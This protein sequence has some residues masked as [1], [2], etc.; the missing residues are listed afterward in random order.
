MTSDV[1][2]TARAWNLWLL[3]GW[4]DV[5]TQYRRSFLGPV[6]ITVSTGV[7]VLA[8]GVL[9]AQLFGMKTEEF[10]PYFAVGYVLFVFLSTV[11]TDGCDT[12]SA[13]E[14][15][16]KHG[17]FPKLVFPLRV[18]VRNVVLLMHNAVIIIAVLISFGKFPSV[19]WIAFSI[20]LLLTLSVA[21]FVIVILGCLSARFRDVPMMVRS[22]MQIMFFMTPVFWTAD[23]LTA[24]GELIVIWNPLA[25]FL[26]LLRSPLL[27]SVPP[28]MQW[29]KGLGWLAGTA[30]VAVLVFLYC[31]RRLVY[32]V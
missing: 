15:Y 17:S 8:F 28:L 24:R 10:L 25:L 26:D 1:I 3:L 18:L 9:G 11:I 31:R 27:G 20:G 19:Q 30:V 4:N 5:A 12:F 29:L 16:L 14:T 23:N 32:W 7:F 13:A 2:A 6:W 22:I 21:V